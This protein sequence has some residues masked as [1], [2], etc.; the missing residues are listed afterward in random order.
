VIYRELGRTGL[1]VSLIALG[2]MTWGEQN[3]EAQAHAQIDAALAAG[4][5]FID[6]AEMYPVPP[7]AETYGRTEA[8]IGTWLK[9]HGQ[10]D[11]IVLASKAAGPA[12]TPARPQ[13]VRGNRTQF[14]AANLSEALHA[15]LGRLQTD[16]LDL[17][18]LHWPDRATNI[19]GQLG[20]QH[21]TDE[22]MT[23]IHET[24]A[25]LSSFVKAGKIRH[26][27][28]SNESPWGICEFLKL[29]QVHGLE[30]VVSVQNPYSLVNRTYEIGHAEI[31]M[32]EQVGLLA[33]S[34]LAFGVLSGKYLAGAL[35]RGGRIT[36]FERFARYKGENTERAVYEY[37]KLFRQHGIDAAQGALAFVNS[38]PFVTSTII[39]ATTLEQLHSNLASI[40]LVLPEPVLA[41]IEQIHQRYPNPAP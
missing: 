39:G 18:Q 21:Q 33:Y 14:T 8:I 17:Y 30:R 27:G 9:R 26:I 34:P 24:L 2:S 25:A 19:F 28:L 23:P 3:D 38:R 20:Y 11:R 4:V 41:G 12:H 37:V 1:K 29:A 31:S 6:T 7:K 10:R 36:R 35:P 15:S 22:A 13:H 5:N 32:R 16:Y 40:E